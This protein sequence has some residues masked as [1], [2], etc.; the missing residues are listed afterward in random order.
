MTTNDRN[1]T[2][3]DRTRLGLP[4]LAR[5]RG[6]AEYLRVFRNGAKHRSAEL[7]L[8]ACPNSF[9]RNRI[10]VS[11]GRKHGK[12]VIRNRTRRRIKEAFRLENLRL[13]QGFDFVCVPQEKGPLEMPIAELRAQFLR[14]AEAVGRKA[15][16]P[17]P[18][19]KRPC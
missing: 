12:A 18:R 10:G 4:K 9:G 6:R 1:G 11:V 17:R 3:R 15:L 2:T 8:Y 7:A 13:P 14:L 5:L 19:R 16:Q